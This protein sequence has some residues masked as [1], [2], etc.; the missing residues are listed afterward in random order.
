M[1]CLFLQRNKDM[2]Y[3]KNELIIEKDWYLNLTKLYYKTDFK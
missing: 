3:K 2:I 1:F